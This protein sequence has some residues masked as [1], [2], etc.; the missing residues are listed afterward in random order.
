[1]IWANLPGDSGQSYFELWH[2]EINV[3]VGGHGE[4]HGAH[5]ASRFTWRYPGRRCGRRAESWLDYLTL[6]HDLHWWI[7]DA[8]M[9]I[10]FLVVGLEIK[11][12]LLV[13][14]LS[15]VRKAAVPLLP[16]LAGWWAPR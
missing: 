16:R 14:E 13:G 11:R 10:F 5:E 12:E 1:M 6:K 3:S 9:A 2:T 15:S 7:N 4:A 8:L